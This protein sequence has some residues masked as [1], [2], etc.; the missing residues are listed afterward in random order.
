MRSVKKIKSLD[1]FKRELIELN[2][3]SIFFDEQKF[4]RKISDFYLDMVRALEPL[5][6]SQEKG[7]NVLEAEMKVYQD[8]LKS[9]L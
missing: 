4:R 9:L 3:K 2:R 8:R 7:I 5:S 1:S 6:E